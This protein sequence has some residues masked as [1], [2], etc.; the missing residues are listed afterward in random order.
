MK[1]IQVGWKYR[2]EIPRSFNEKCTPLEEKKSVTFFKI[3]EAIFKLGDPPVVKNSTLIFV[4]D[5]DFKLSKL[6]DKWVGEFDN[7]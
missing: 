5:L 4:D 1:H 7:L 6:K 3:V 2:I